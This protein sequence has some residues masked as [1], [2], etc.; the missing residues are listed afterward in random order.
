MKVSMFAFLLLAIASFSAQ[1][2]ETTYKAVSSCNT[3]DGP[4]D[5]GLLQE[6]SGKY[7]F[8]AFRKGDINPV[9]FDFGKLGK[10]SACGKSKGNKSDFS[11]EVKGRTIKQGN[12]LVY[13]ET[14]CKEDEGWKAVRHI[15]FL[16][17]EFAEIKFFPESRPC[18]LK[19]FTKRAQAAQREAAVR[20]EPLSEEALAPD[21]IEEEQSVDVELK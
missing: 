15:R 20:A 8:L 2:K 7:D 16:D 19:I 1:A 4:M 5:H 18:R 14:G 11:G 3:G 9:E 13:Q 6:K 21:A 17:K 12:S 10:V